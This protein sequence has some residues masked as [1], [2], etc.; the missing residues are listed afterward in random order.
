MASLKLD[1]GVYAS[2]IVGG[3]VTFVATE[4]N[5]LYALD[6]DG[7]QVWRTHLGAPARR[8]DLPCG[9]IDPSGITGTP[10]YAD[11]VV[12][13]VAEHAGPVRHDLVALSARDGT[14]RWRVSVDLPGTD[15]A[16]MQERGA[17]AVSG[18]RVWVPFGGRFGD[19]GDYKG[20]V[21]GVRLDGTDP[22]AYTVPTSREAGI[23]APPGVVVDSRG[24]LL[25]AVG[26]GE[27]GA[28][29]SYDHSDSVLRLS[30]D[31]T[32]V[33]SFS[34][35]DWASDNAYD[36]DLGSQGPVLVGERWVFIAGKSGTGYVLRADHLGGIGGGVWQGTVCRSFGGA[37]VDATTV[38]VPCDDGVRAL[39]IDATG[40]ARIQWHAS[41]P[42]SPVIGGGRVWTLD[43][44]AGAL[45]A[46]DPATGRSTAQVAVG[47]TS[48]FATPALHGNHVLVPTMTGL[49]IVAAR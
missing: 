6:D 37:A 19:C 5:S 17:L 35:T 39:R 24:D 41:V 8:S 20:R 7:Q 40:S 3:G 46:L 1:A 43:A 11:G 4:N 38:Y 18:G 9:N 30:T 28:G 34:P 29:D 36:L 13:V 33:D 45:H 10:V 32:L 14:V 31:A 21:V 2:P 44:D 27:Y 12:Y 23:W 49:A 26:N 16:A 22:I 42:G 47:V 15:P 25:V 48:R